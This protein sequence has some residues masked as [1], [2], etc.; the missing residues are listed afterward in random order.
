MK[1]TIRYIREELKGVFPLTGITAISGMILNALRGYSLTDMVVKEE[2]ILTVRETDRVKEIVAR[3]SHHEPIQYIL[4]YT[5]F[6]GIPIRVNPS[7]L[8]PRPETEELVDWIVREEMAGPLRITDIGTGSG[9]IALALKKAFPLSEVEG[10]D[11]SK[12]ALSLARENAKA[13]NLQLTFFQAD[14]LNWEK[15]ASWNFADIIVSNPPYVTPGEKEL[16]QPN[17]IRYEPQTALFVP[18]DDPLVYYRKILELARNQLNSGGK[19]YLEINEHFGKEME[20][21][22]TGSG[23]GQ[24]EIRNDLQGKQRMARGTLNP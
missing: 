14:I 20:I 22:L 3:L 11:F 24:V 18:E 8:I 13:N 6:W 15:S 12:E 16:M 7:V 10:C 2:E 4:G 1:A 17:V 21:L 9:C 19:V 5:Q 23:F